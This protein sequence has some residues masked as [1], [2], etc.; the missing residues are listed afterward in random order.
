MNMSNVTFEVHRLSTFVFKKSSEKKNPD[1]IKRL[2]DRASP[3][4]Q[5][6]SKHGT[7][8]QFCFNVGPDRVA[9]N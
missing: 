4:W 3:V 2:G 8:T 1:Y 6:G 9:Y 7:I 5:Y